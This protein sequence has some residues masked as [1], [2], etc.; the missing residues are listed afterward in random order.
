M[1]TLICRYNQFE[2]RHGKL[3]HMVLYFTQGLIISLKWEQYVNAHNNN[4]HIKTDACINYR[5]S[6]YKGPQRSGRVN[7]LSEWVAW[8]FI[9]L[10]NC[11]FISD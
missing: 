7:I 5:S 8:D 11:L 2:W 1:L 10:D 4:L 3:K 6:W 9:I